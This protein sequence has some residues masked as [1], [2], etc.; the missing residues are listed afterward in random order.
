MGVVVVVVVV[1]DGVIY[2]YRKLVLIDFA[3]YI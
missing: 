2:I 3:A 1:V